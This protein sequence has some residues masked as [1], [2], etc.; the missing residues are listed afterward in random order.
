[1]CTFGPRRLNVWLMPAYS[2]F[3]RVT[4]FLNTI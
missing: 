3:L 1:V 4:T 2:G